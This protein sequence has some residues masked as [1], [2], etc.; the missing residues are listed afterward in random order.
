MGP[1]GAQQVRQVISDVQQITIVWYHTWLVSSAA[2]NVLS[3]ATTGSHGC[4]GLESKTVRR[5]SK[6]KSTACGTSIVRICTCR[7]FA[8]G[9]YCTAVSYRTLRGRRGAQ[10]QSAFLLAFAFWGESWFFS[11]TVDRAYFAAP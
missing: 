6:N 7:G 11:F 9:A 5:I 4:F 10:L 3:F 2:L 1:D 8:R